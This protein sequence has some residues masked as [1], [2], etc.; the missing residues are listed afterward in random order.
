[1]FLR[2]SGSHRYVMYY[3]C[4]CFMWLNIIEWELIIPVEEVF[5]RYVFKVIHMSPHQPLIW[6]DRLEYWRPLQ[7]LPWAFE[8]SETLLEQAMVC[9]WYQWL[10]LAEPPI[11]L[12]SSH[13]CQLSQ[14]PALVKRNSWEDSGETP[15]TLRWSPS[16]SYLLLINHCATKIIYIL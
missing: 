12:K 9:E 4:F 10:M 15:D 1:M 16:H 7:H 6:E 3:Y 11:P 14:I 5:Y 8:F 2:C 13:S